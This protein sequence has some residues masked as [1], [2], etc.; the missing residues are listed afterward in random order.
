METWQRL[1]QNSITT[2]RQLARVLPV[3]EREIEEVIS[4]YPMRINPYY[5]G[6]IHAEG[7]PLWR[8]AVPSRLELEDHAGLDDPLSEEPQSPVP[9][10][11]HRY[12]DRVLLLVSNQ[13]AM[14]CRFCT[15]KRKVGHPFV[16][17]EETINQGLAYIETTPNVRDVLLS[18]GDPLLLADERLE[19]ILT[20]VRAVPHVEIVRIGSRVPCTLP[21]RVTKRLSSLLRKFAPLY[22]NIHFNHPDEITPEVALACGRLADAGIPLGSQTVLLR[23]VNDSAPVMKRLMQRLVAVRVRPYYLYQCD[24]TR[25]TQHFRTTVAEGLGVMQGL[26]GYTSGLCVPQ[27]IVDSPGGKIPLL[28]NYVVAETEHSLVLRNYENRCFAYPEERP[29]PASGPGQPA[30][31]EPPALCGSA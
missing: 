28:P 21:Q 23:G 26:R 29:Q 5:L 4:R 20:R 17:T 19:D 24:L 31:L 27:F 10:L 14:Y 12:P 1:L 30:Q 3:A 18:G 2:A 25:G 11:V 13:C 6:L 8:Q 22:I 15:R 16:V 9:G 7:S